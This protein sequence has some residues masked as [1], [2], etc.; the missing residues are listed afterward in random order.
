VGDLKCLRVRVD[1]A[2]HDAATSVT[3]SEVVVLQTHPPTV[4]PLPVEV[5][6]AEAA[7]RLGVHP[8]TI[9]RAVRRGH[10]PARQVRQAGRAVWIVALDALATYHAQG[11]S[12]VDDARAGVDDSRTTHPAR[13]DDGHTTV[14]ALRAHV[15]DLQGEVARLRADLDAARSEVAARSADVGRL[16]EA[17]AALTTTAL[18]KPAPRPWWRIW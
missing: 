10:L 18:P 11:V 6:T 3:R 14:A 4:A 16:V 17:L 5:D 15:A 12:H 1:D 9:R 7:R 8:E 2:Q 13:V